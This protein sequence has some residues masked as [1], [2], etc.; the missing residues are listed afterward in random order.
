MR[1]Y[2]F[3]AVALAI[4]L[5]F[6]SFSAGNE[7]NKSVFPDDCWGV[8]SW[9]GWNIKNVNRQSHPLIK[10]A[11][12]ILKWRDV[13]PEPGVF[14]FDEILGKQLQEAEENQFYTFLM[15][16][17]AP[18]AP[19]WLYENGVPELEMTPTIGPLGQARDWTFQYY[20]DEDYMRFFHR[21]LTEFGNYIRDLPVELR[22]RI[23]YVQS[24]EGSTGDGW[25]YKG[26]PLDLKYDIT[27]D[28]W[29]VF[30]IQAWEVLKAALSDKSGN[31]VV[32]ILVN[33][34][35][36]REDQYNWVLKNL[37]VVGLK[38]GMFSHGYHISDTKERV[39]DWRQFTSEVK[40]AGKEFFSRGE[41][42]AEYKTYGWSTQN[43]S[44]GLYWSAI[45]ATYCGLDMWNVPWE[46]SAGYE[47]KDALL[48][49]NK[50]A[51]H[52][53]PSTSPA[54]FCALR[55]GLDASDVE[56]YPENKYG[57]ASKKNID[58]YLKIADAYKKY[59]AIQGDPP[60]AIGGGM[61]NR[62]RQDYNDVG[63]GIHDG[64]YQRF[65]EQ[66]DPEATSIGW[67]H[68]GPAKSV[69]SRFARSTDV[70]NGNNALYFDLDDAFLAKQKPVEVKVIWLDEGKSEW[71]LRYNSADNPEKD[72]FTVK[73]RGTGEWQEKTVILK[74][75]NPGNKGR[76]GSDLVIE[77]DGKDDLVVHLLEVNKK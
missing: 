72:A 16:W 44:Q 51:G 67:W 40:A 9:G 56:L 57:D 37:R 4:V 11:P 77:C 55:K 23:L 3:Y 46:A 74:D 42:D 62:K 65:I 66:I 54:A 71:K 41:Q 8:Y 43:I 25:G 68:K 53:E 21:L 75:F 52:H 18:G 49:F 69:Y 60:K 61:L 13:E 34:D 26:K 50:Y 64:N 33:Y 12:M 36:N 45:F 58:R 15:I 35:S 32:P 31:P 63:W 39:R 14:L 17:V 29:G 20:L 1:N 28:Q 2:L 30:R 22:E 6:C 73:N 70:A 47:H 19:E 38:N 48:F 10:G 27:D 7:S 24:A 5:S 76:L 59:G